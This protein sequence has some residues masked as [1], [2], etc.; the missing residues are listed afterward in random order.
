MKTAVRSLGD[1]ANIHDLRSI[2][3]TRKSAKPAL[4]TTAILDL[5]MSRNERDRLVKER[6][7]LSKR[8]IQ[9]NRRLTEIDGE[10]DELLER[11]RAKAAEIR[12]EGG[13]SLDITIKGK[14]GKKVILGY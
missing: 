12:G 13:V 5:Y 7:K 14:R 2:P 3:R 4:P 11:A 8:N 9:I 6:Q 1:I 10:M